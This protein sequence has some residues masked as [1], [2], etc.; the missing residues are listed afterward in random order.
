MPPDRIFEPDPSMKYY[1]V[2]V[3]FRGLLLSVRLAVSGS[4]F[5]I[6]DYRPPHGTAWDWSFIDKNKGE[7]FMNI[8]FDPSS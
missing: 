4:N 8:P 6:V 7:I 5:E 2:Q 3:P 1:W